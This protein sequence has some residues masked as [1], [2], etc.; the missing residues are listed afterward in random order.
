M[1]FWTKNPTNLIDQDEIRHLWPNNNNGFDSNLNALTRLVILLSVIGFIMNRSFWNLTI[2][3]ISIFMIILFYYHTSRS[4]GFEGMPDGV[5]E[6]SM[7]EIKYENVTS[8][9]PMSNILVNEIGDRPDRKPARPSF[10][11]SA[12]DKINKATKQ[13]IKELNPDNK[14]IDK[15]LFKSI[16]DE[17][18]FDSSMRN[19]Y[20][21]PNTTVPNNQTDFAKFCYGNLKSRK[22]ENM[23]SF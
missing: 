20:S 23:T 2:G 5:K 8:K 10:V 4:E 22:E 17:F 1:E 19:F 21:T 6:P 18:E 16:G 9:N 13:M 15:R 11:G 3:L 12:V 14:D 7:S